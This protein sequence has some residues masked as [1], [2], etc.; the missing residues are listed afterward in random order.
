MAPFAAGQFRSETLDKRTL[1]RKHPF[2]RDLAVGII[3]HLAPSAS[4][5]KIKKGTTLFRK[6]DVGPRLYAI[7]ADI[8]R[9]SVPSASGTEAVFSLMVPGEVFGEITLL[10]GGVRTVD[11]IAVED[12]ELMVIERRDFIPMLNS[13]PMPSAEGC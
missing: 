8:V 5:R 3:G 6:G 9:I 10:D 1:F 4:T 11:A 12:C 2:F 13:R 7:P